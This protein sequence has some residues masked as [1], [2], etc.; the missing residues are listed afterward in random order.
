MASVQ[1]KKMGLPVGQ[2]PW[3]IV[4]SRHKEAEPTMSFVPEPK[5]RSSYGIQ[6]IAGKSGSRL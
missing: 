2:Q 1:E 3:S 5:Y 4:F 6:R